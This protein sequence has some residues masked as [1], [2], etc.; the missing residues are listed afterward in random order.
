MKN[1][2]ALIGL[3]F[4]FLASV[5]N[6]VVLDV[7]DLAA[8]PMDQAALNEISSKQKEA[9]QEKLANEC[10]LSKKYKTLNEKL[11]T[12]NK[13]S[14]T[15]ISEYQAIR[16]VQ[17]S[18]LSR[19][20]SDKKPIE[21]IY[22]IFK[23]QYALPYEKQSAAVWDDWAVGIKQLEPM[24]DAFK[25]G[26]TFNIIDLKKIH[27][28]L[29]PFFPMIDE[30]GD[31]AHNPNPGVL[32]PTA[33]DESDTYWWSFRTAEEASAALAVVQNENEK[34]KRLGLV[35]PAP[36]G[37]PDYV[38]HILDVREWTD[39]DD[40]SKKVT[41]ITSGSAVVNRQNIELILNMIDTLMKQARSGQHM[42]WK[43]ILFT[44]AQLAYFVQQVYVRVHAFYEGNGRTSRFLQEL[45]LMSF[46]L[47]HGA[48]GDLMDIDVLTESGEYYDKAIKAN[49]DLLA[50]M[51]KCYEEY[52]E[53]APQTDARQ[54]DQSKLSYGCRILADRAG[55]WFDMRRENEIT[56]KANFESATKELKELDRRNEIG[57]MREMARRAR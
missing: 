14:L 15:D 5:A 24:V 43:N 56:N 54:I 45:I 26:E 40:S 25:N 17:R 8:I 47:P 31:F 55:T 34:Y 12:K 30:H 32:K 13:V 49:F 11:Q 29:F 38:S 19:A 4:I 18:W 6:A 10:D 2:I 9:Y 7:C 42:V 48:S 33:S 21:I 50:K 36:A 27:R 39:R 51:K 46:N 53:I 23:T 41:A 1:K 22:Q 3:P 16:F 37:L 35:T 52:K 20:E 44:P 28:G 57:H